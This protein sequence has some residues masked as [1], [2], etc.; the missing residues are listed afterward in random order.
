[1]SRISRRE[2][3]DLSSRMDRLGVFE[4]QSR[5]G[6][7]SRNTCARRDAAAM[8]RFMPM[9]GWTL[10]GQPGA[11]TG[12]LE[13]TRLCGASNAD[14][15]LEVFAL[16]VTGTMHHIKETA[17]D[18]WSQ[19][20]I[21]DHKTGGGEHDFSTDSDPYVARQSDGR[22]QVFAVANRK[23]GS[24]RSI[25]QSHPVTTW[26]SWGTLSSRVSS[27][28]FNE[29]IDYDGDVAP[30]IAF[31]E[32]QDGRL[33][34]A[35]TF[36]SGGLTTLARMWQTK[37]ANGWSDD[38]PEFSDSQPD[39]LTGLAYANQLDGRLIVFGMVESTNTLWYIGEVVAN[40]QWGVW[41]PLHGTVGFTGTPAL[42]RNQDGR[43]EVFV[44]GVDGQLWHTAQVAPNDV[45]TDERWSTVGTT[46]STGSP[47]ISVD[48]ENRM[49]VFTFASDGIWMSRQELPNGAWSDWYFLGG[50]GASI[51]RL[52]PY[53][54]FRTPVLGGM[55]VPVRLRV[56]AIASGQLWFRMLALTP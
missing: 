6:S 30:P 50:E 7:L 29:S 39:G 49:T 12:P 40:H 1:M 34:A 36:N 3:L 53:P 55:D 8:L 42:G 32:H 56:F 54:T 14:R 2:V 28:N 37:A 18:V 27:S 35:F 41:A 21:L 26:G 20:A 23:P 4:P 31:G 45:W 16:D 15:T 11:E 48:E 17:P 51:A 25:A 38:A 24:L 47:L 19:W 10:L 13:L 9:D 5:G 33:D 22:L 46:T 44:T 43:L 52:Q